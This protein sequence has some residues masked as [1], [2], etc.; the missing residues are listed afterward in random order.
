[1]KIYT[2]F[3]L[4]LVLVM[5]SSVWG[6][7]TQVS[8]TVGRDAIGVHDQL[9]FTVTV[10]G[11]NSGEA[12]NPRLPDFRGFKVVS[13]PS[14]GTQ[15]QW[16]N[17]RSRSSKSFTYILVP[18]KEGQFTLDPVEVR[19]G[20]KTYKTET[21]QVRVTSAPPDPSPRRRTARDPWDPFEEDI[22]PVRQPVGDAVFLRAE[23]DLESA[24][25]GQQVTLFYRLYTSMR[26]GGIQIKEAP[27]LAGFWV[28]DL[29]VDKNPKGT[30]ETIN[31]REY[32][33]YTIKKQALFA[34]TTGRLKIPG[35]T[36]AISVESGRDIFSIF[37]R[38]ET[39]YR[40][41][42]DL[43][44]EVKPL[45]Q[46]GK[47]E[48]FSNAVGKFK[49]AASIDKNEVAAG[50]AVALKVRLEGQGNLKTITELSLPDLPDF[51]IYSSKQEEKTEVSEKNQIGGEKTWEYVIV[52]KA[53]GQQ[54]IPSIAFSFYNADRDRYETASTS[55]IA[56]SVTG[57]N[58]DIVDTPG[59]FDINKQEL[60][61]RGTDIHFIKLSA[62]S[63]ERYGAPLYRQT[64]FY[65]MFALPIMLNASVLLYRKQQSRLTEN[66]VVARSRKAR[67]NALKKL[68]AA[69][70]EGKT[71]PRRYYDLA[72]SALSGYLADRYNLQAIE[73]TSDNL[74]RTLSVKTV[75]REIIEETKGCLEECDFGRFVSAEASPDK[76]TGLSARIRGN[77][78]A[79]EKVTGET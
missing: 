36:F 41:T 11:E 24:Y 39:I 58:T 20:D 2:L 13:G 17:G 12:E 10:S 49:L 7:D 6:Q 45:P 27:T 69:E 35:S 30:N 60:T 74:E 5:G 22:T 8:A 32:L 47:P 26:V 70:R 9:Q 19:I 76:I 62:G 21:V 71:D 37:D 43:A 72:A 34:N 33:A 61:R 15:F 23:L 18:E 14:I 54:A 55:P 44:L 38:S 29:E 51:T 68:K 46:E 65:F 31:G 50:E 52:P 64:W 40:N 16:I 78:D 67:Q 63:F 48:N 77:I 1:M 66:T 25:P 53:P 59:L 73:L 3:I 42:Q 75:S 4:S 79:L 57:G 28:E 56:L